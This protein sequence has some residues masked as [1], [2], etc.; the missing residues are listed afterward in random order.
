MLPPQDEVT[1][2]WAAALAEDVPEAEV[3]VATDDDEANAL[4]PSA[5]AAYG[6]LTAGLL[7]NAGRLAWLQ[8]PAA[9]PPAGYFFDELIQ[10]PVV[11]TNLRGIYND[12]VAIHAM[13][14]VL[15]LARGLQHYVP[16][17]AEGRW[18]PDRTAGGVIHLPEATM[19]VVGLGGIGTESARMARAFGI[20][21]LATDARVTDPPDGIDEL[22][23]PSGLDDLLPRADIVV[24]TVPHTP[25]TEGLIDG[26]RLGLMKP[27]AVLVNIGR[28]RTVRLDDLVAALHAGTIAGAG[29]DVFEIEP[30]PS[31]HPLWT[32]PNVLLTPH[33][34][35]AGPYLEERRYGV[36]V[37]N[38]RRY[39]AGRE[40]LNV[41]DKARWF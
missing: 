4:I 41:V 20:K 25:E 38:A 21:V 35:V 14:F 1:L 29:L 16:G 15:A 22:R 6:T 30:L 27:T 19:L 7:A 3:V 10:H 5:D 18:D 8:A 32:T 17:Q 36:L 24:L 26:R 2:A 9:A 13:A 23:D 40:L 37:E 28:G 39:A 31:D 12:H 33:T 11:V 34:A